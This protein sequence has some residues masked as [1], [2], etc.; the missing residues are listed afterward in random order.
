MRYYS[1][2]LININAG[3]IEIWDIG[4]PCTKKEAQRYA[5]NQAFAKNCFILCIKAT[6]NYKGREW[7]VWFAP[8]T[9]LNIG[10]WKF[11]GLPGLILKAEDSENHYIFECVDILKIDRDI[12]LSRWSESREVPKDEFVK[13]L[14]K[15]KTN[16]IDFTTNQAGIS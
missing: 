9:H 1:A 14:M 12:N 3:L 15:F 5:K 13:L 2:I 7:V 11:H 4:T 8:E 10:P 16:P 6:T